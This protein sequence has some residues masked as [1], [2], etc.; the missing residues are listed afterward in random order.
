ML[1]LLP[2]HSPLFGAG[3]FERRRVGRLGRPLLTERPQPLPRDVGSAATFEE[4]GSSG[5]VL[6]GKKIEKERA[7]QS[8]EK[9]D[10]DVS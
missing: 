10:E 4:N 6:F 7:E 2:R 3:V 8:K 1:V 5:T 9:R